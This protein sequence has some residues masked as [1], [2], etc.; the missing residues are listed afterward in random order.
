MSYDTAHPLQQRLVQ[1]FGARW[2]TPET[3]EAFIAEPGDR[4]LFLSGDPVRFPEALDVA[5]VLPELQAAHPGRFAVGVVDRE[6][7]SE[8]AR[9]FGSNRWPALVFLRDGAYVTTLAGMHDWTDY[10]AKVGEALDA[11]VG[12]APTIGIPL[13]AATAGAGAAPACH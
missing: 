8:I 13:V 3:L 2:I 11:P 1:Q 10:V 6:H 12:R 5:V 7:E 9:R 4:V